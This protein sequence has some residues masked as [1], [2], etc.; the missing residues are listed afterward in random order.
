MADHNGFHFFPH[1][2]MSNLEMA[3]W[4]VIIF[5]SNGAALEYFVI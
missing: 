3:F 4:G 5:P 1:W 2:G